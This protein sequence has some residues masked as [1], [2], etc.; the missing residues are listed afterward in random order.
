[1]NTPRGTFDAVPLEALFPDAGVADLDRIRRSEHEIDGVHVSGKPPLWQWFP[2][3][4]TFPGRARAG[5]PEVLLAEVSL[6]DEGADWLEAS[7]DVE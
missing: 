6:Y 1:M 2:Q 7:L 3:H 4:V 5:T